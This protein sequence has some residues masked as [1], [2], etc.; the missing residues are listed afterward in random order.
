M[1]SGGRSNAKNSSKRS[2]NPSKKVAKATR[3]TSAKTKKS[4]TASSRNASSG[5]KK[6]Q[7]A[8]KQIENRHK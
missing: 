2:G 6:K 8:K 5:S 4:K 3:N 1:T 7:I